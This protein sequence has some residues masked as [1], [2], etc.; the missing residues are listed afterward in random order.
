MP[1]TDER[2]DCGSY[3]SDEELDGVDLE[4]VLSGSGGAVYGENLGK[5]MEGEYER[6]VSG[7]A[8]MLADDADVDGD[9]LR[10]GHT[11]SHHEIL[12]RAGEDPVRLAT[13]GFIATD[14]DGGLEIHNLFA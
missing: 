4:G 10:V 9:I 6:Q 1:E 12:R 7:V 5:L 11:Q 2:L 3:K 13:C 8:E 14:D